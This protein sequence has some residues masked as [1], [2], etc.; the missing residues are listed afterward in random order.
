[1]F[2][3]RYTRD[4]FVLL[5]LRDY[6][7]IDIDV[8]EFRSNDVTP[9]DGDR[10]WIVWYSELGFDLPHWLGQEYLSAQLSGSSCGRCAST[11]AE[12][13]V[14][15]SQI[16]QGTGCFYGQKCFHQRCLLLGFRNTQEEYQ[17]DGWLL[18]RWYAMTKGHIS[19]TRSTTSRRRSNVGIERCSEMSVVKLTGASSMNDKDSTTM[20]ILSR[21]VESMIHS[22][23]CTGIICMRWRI[24]LLRKIHEACNET[25]SP[26]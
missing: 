15:Q 10:R 23:R 8:Y 7:T 13:W 26:A 24:R 22:E 21:R 25:C 16:I 6:Q 11:N 1:M 14:L 4:S 20:R 5:H 12:D 9:I 19:I 17:W 18:M 2:S 3:T